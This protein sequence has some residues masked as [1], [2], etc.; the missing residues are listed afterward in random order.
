MRLNPRTLRQIDSPFDA[1]YSLLEGRCK[2][3]ELLDLAQGAP[4]YPAAPAVV[5]HVAAVAREA[6]GG[7]YVEIAGLP[8]LRQAFADELS[9]AYGGRISEGNVVV[10][11][12]CNQAFCLIA[13]A[14]AEAGD[15]IVLTTPFYPNHDMWLRLTGIRPVYLEPGPDLVP[16]VE[17]AEA[18]VTPRTRAIVLITPGNP[19]GMTLDPEVIAEFAEFAA[20]RGIALILDE[21]YRSFRDT[22]EPAHKLFSDPGWD[23]T[24]VSLHS[25]SKDFALPGYRVGAVVASPSVNRE[26]LKLLDCVAICAPRIGQEAAWAGLTGARQ[27]RR[28]RA[29][30][31]AANRRGFAEAMAGRPGGFELVSVGGFFGWMRHPFA[32]RPTGEVVRD[33]AIHLD[34]LV[35][36]GTAFLPGDQGMIRVSVGNL[37]G[38]AFADLSDR[39]AALRAL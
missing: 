5:E 25:F 18:L 30:E 29:G 12:G 32:G 36:P 35:I 15:E 1:A 3:R 37:E 6:N 4:P 10:T 33:L 16:A 31:L 21:T 26:V 19:S 2:K 8:Q 22:E 27:W 20:R 14:L 28:E 39:L 11:A 13:S 9:Q 34:T 38:E 17:R 24:V 23:E 7:A